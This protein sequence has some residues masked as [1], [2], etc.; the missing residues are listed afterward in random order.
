MTTVITQ[1][2]LGRF[3]ALARQWR[4]EDRRLVAADLDV[5]LD[6]IEARRAA[7][8][9]VLNAIVKGDS[10]PELHAEALAKAAALWGPEAELAVEETHPVR[11]LHDTSEGQFSADVRVRCLNYEEIAP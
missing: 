7:G 6:E 3:R 5:L 2:D 11:T 8:G 1:G 10:V 9:D 4:A